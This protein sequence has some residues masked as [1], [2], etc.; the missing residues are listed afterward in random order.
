MVFFVWKEQQLNKKKKRF[1]FFFVYIGV[2]V[3][4]KTRRNK[5]VLDKEREES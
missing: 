2:L 1:G 4:I 3:F 5:T